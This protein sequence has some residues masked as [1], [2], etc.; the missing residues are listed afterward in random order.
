MLATRTQLESRLGNAQEKIA[1]ATKTTNSLIVTNAAAF[2]AGYISQK[3][4]G[5]GEIEVMGLP[6]VPTAGALLAGAALLGVGGKK[7]RGTMLDVS[8]GITA[9]FLYGQGRK[10]A[11]T[12]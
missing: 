1:S 10:L 3:M 2:G 6:L 9:A 5:D 4:A 11:K 12:K 7:A 8:K